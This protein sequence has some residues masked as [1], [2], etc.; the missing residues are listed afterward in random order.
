LLKINHLFSCEGKNFLKQSGPRLQEL[1]VTLP[2][3]E[4][5]AGRKE[6]NAVAIKRLVCCSNRLI[7]CCT[8][9]RL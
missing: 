6:R 2:F 7:F 3:E 4:N 5:F 1:R 9:R 8:P